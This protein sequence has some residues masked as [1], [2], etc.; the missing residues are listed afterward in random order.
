MTIWAVDHILRG[1]SFMQL[2]RL[3][4]PVEVRVSDSEPLV[5]GIVASVNIF[6]E[7][8]VQV[9][10]SLLGVFALS[11]VRPHVRLHHGTLLIL[12]KTS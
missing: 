2:F 9:P 10:G 12:L 3:S 11:Q 1:P 4:D 7:V 6:G 8:L 5:L